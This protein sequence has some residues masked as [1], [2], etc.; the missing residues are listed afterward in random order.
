MISNLARDFH[1]DLKHHE[2]ERRVPRHQPPFRFV[3]D[4]I[5]VAKDD[6]GELSEKPKPIEVELAEKTT[7]K[8]S[9]HI[10]SNVENF[11]K[12]QKQHDYILLQQKAKSKW[13]GL[14]KVAVDCENKIANIDAATA[15]QADK[16][17]LKD[18]ET[19]ANKVTLQASAL[20]VKAFNLYQQMSAPALR[21]E[22][23]DIVQDECFST[24]W[25]MPDG[26]EST[27]TRGQTW[28]TLAKCKRDHL[29]TWCEQDAAERWKTYVNQNLKKPQRLAIKPF[30]KRL[31]ELDD[32]VPDLPCLKDEDDCP[33]EVTRANVSMTGF[34]MCTL[35]MRL[36]TDEVAEEYDVLHPK[37]PIDPKK[38]VK[39]LEKIERKLKYYIPKPA[40][41][42]DKNQ[43][44]TPNGARIPAKNKRTRNGDAAK[45]DRIPRKPP[46]AP[47]KD[48][49][50]FCSLCD[51]YGGVKHSH[52]TNDC[53]RWTNNGKD[54]PEWRGRTATSH[55]NNFNNEVIKSL[56]AQQTELS[57]KLLNQVNKLKKK[58][59]SR[60]RRNGNRYDDSSSSDSD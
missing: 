31:K 40:D 33:S 10:F 36:V 1:K 42:R 12:H 18:L 52:N 51:K 29:L 20:V 25:I 26:S 2:A 4:R 44:G 59:R 46:K 38:L 53:K 8:V 16:K 30:H 24:G 22:W 60:K 15:N 45:H 57:N 47:A 32:L 5:V 37:V 3:P 14:V 7:T 58:K 13:E 56:M 50:K 6:D 21:V 19:L 35:L 11:L 27:V 28:E 49:G 39:E 17:K 34:E 48:T 41:S 54:H 9:P 55:N 23:N 43:S